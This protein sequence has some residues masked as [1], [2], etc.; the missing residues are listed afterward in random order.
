MEQAKEAKGR[1]EAGRGGGGGGVMMVEEQKNEDLYFIVYDL[2]CNIA[3][4]LSDKDKLELYGL[5]KQGTVGACNIPKPSVLDMIGA[6]K[7]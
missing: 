4:G 6:A 3:Q 2:Y 1:E 7:W 5:Y